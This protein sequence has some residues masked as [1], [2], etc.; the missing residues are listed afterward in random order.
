MKINYPFPLENLTIKIGYISM[1]GGAY[2]E[3]KSV[4]GKTIA[5]L[6][7][8]VGDIR[9]MQMLPFDVIDI[10]N[11]AE[12]IGFY[13]LD[14]NG[15]IGTESFLHLDENGNVSDSAEPGPLEI[16]T[17]I[18]SYTISIDTGTQQKYIQVD[19][20]AETKFFT[21]MKNYIFKKS[22][23]KIREL[24]SSIETPPRPS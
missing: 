20:G 14:N 24:W 11:Y 19:A 15:T 1:C 6:T 2:L 18:P 3:I 7:P 10:L 16:C 5:Q 23:F 8:M 21:M 4:A 13:N 22:G 9:Q 17:D 12:E